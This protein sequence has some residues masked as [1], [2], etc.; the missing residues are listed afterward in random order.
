MYTVPTPGVNVGTFRDRK[1]VETGD[2]NVFCLAINRRW[3]IKR[4]PSRR[5]FHLTISSALLNHHLIHLWYCC[6]LL[7]LCCIARSSFGW[8]H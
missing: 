1:T 3:R 5:Y 2:E 6:L 8:V 4:E 7:T